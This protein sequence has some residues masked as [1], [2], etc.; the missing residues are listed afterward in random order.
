MNIE[1]II[2]ENS[3]LKKGLVSYEPLNGGLNNQTFKVITK[4]KS[5]VVRINGKQNEYLKVTR[6]SEVEIME[7]ASKE[8]ITPKVVIA[9]Q[10]EKYIVTEFIDGRM[11]SEDDLNDEIMKKLIIHHLKKIH[12]MK[13][14]NRSCSPYHFIDRYMDGANELHVKHPDG[15][16]PFLKKAEEI[17]HKRSY[18]KQYNG[19]FCHN[20]FFTV[21]M[22]TSA[23]QLFIIDWEM[24][25][26][27]DIF[28]DLATIPFSSRFSEER[29]KEW[30]TLY[31]GNYEEEQFQI[32]QEMKFMHMVREC[33]W[34]MFYS[35]LDEHKVNHDFDYYKHTLYV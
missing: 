22:L 6:N 26:S 25:G 12:G 15:L 13:T 14:T 17:D 16:L 29:E 9:H 31:F 18:D 7:A 20:D 21:N 23:E 35:G 24:A 32:L 10:P 33:A 19:R 5:F 30:L 28:F 8:G 4:Q 3:L 1:Q 2:Q 27:G 11:I 34:G